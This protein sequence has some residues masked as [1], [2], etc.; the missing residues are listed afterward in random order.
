MW[1][2]RI[3]DHVSPDGGQLT[4][5]SIARYKAYIFGYALTDLYLEEHG[6]KFSLNSHLG[7]IYLSIYIY[8][9]KSLTTEKKK[10]KNLFRTFKIISD[11]LDGITY[12]KY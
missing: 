1:L 6:L 7:Y 5:I 10:Y 11:T 3:S 8:S 12:K 2:L 4:F 9:M